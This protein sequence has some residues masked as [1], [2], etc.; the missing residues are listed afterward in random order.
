MR[1]F[2][3]NLSLSIHYYLDIFYMGVAH[4]LT[5]TVGI[6]S[7]RTSY[8]IKNLHLSLDVSIKKA[9]MNLNGT[10]RMKWTGRIL[11]RI[12][13]LLELF[14]KYVTATFLETWQAEIIF[15]MFLC[16]L[17][18]WL[19]LQEIFTADSK[20]CT[21]CV[22]QYIDFQT[23]S[24]GELF[25]LLGESLKT[26]LDEAH[27]AVNLYSFPQPLVSQ[28]NPSF[29]SPPKQN[30]FQNSPLLQTHQQQSQCVFFPQF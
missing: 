20:I 28:A 26:T 14:L 25:V 29:C 4:H 11:K 30:K 3:Q 7:I 17:R 27:F 5:T 9:L 1:C 6:S 24:V 10:C 13:S 16:I 15:Q 19:V 21:F 8:Q 18:K 23:Q 22:I 2:I 12:E